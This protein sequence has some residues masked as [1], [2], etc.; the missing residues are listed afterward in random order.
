MLHSINSKWSNNFDKSMHR[1]G[2]L[3]KGKFNVTFKCQQRIK[4]QALSDLYV[5]FCSWYSWN[6]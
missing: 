4:G 3:E 2:I 5:L 6:F 1:R